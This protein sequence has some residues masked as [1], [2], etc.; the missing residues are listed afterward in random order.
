MTGAAG[1]VAFP[2]ARELA[3]HNDVWGLAR[4]SSPAARERLAEVFTAFMPALRSVRPSRCWAGIRVLT[5]DG[6]FVIGPDPAVDGFFW[7]AGLGGHGMTTA[8]GVGAI[9]AAGIVEGAL[10]SPYADAFDVD[11]FQSATAPVGARAVA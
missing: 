6:R 8:C 3:K 2:V 11:R 5:P 9:S 1:R 7:V 4:F 10:P